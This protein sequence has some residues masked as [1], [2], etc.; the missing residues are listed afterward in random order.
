MSDDAGEPAGSVPATA[1]RLLREARERQGLHIAAL[2]AAI[3]V[4]PKKLELLES[5][6]FDELP[7]NT[8]TRALTQ[9]VCRALKTDSAAVMRL[10][11]PLVG[12]RLEQPGGGLNAPFRERPGALVQGD[13]MQFAG[14]PFFWAVTVFVVAAIA[15]YLLPASVTALATGRSPAASAPALRGAVEPGMPPGMAD[16]V[17]SSV[18]P[19]GAAGGLEQNAAPTS[20]GAAS[21]ALAT[22]ESGSMPMP[23]PIQAPVPTQ[24]PLAVAET[25]IGSAP[26][27][28]AV[29]AKSATAAPQAPVGALPPGLLQLQATAAS[30]IDVTDGRGKSLVSRLVRPGEAIGVDGVPPLKLRIGNAAGT[31][32]MFRGQPT[33]L[34][35]FTR[36]NVAR[37]ELK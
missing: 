2:A 17:A 16:G 6:R 20:P 34:Q 35:A 31:Q 7:D 19:I 13:W 23:T 24:L 5:D 12:H 10:L 15:L 21:A 25:P 29:I 36:D 37:L 14:N 32:V 9:T 3:K 4:S 30:W 1:G 18:A 33:E 28:S 11:P 27:S 22:T 26:A 8:F